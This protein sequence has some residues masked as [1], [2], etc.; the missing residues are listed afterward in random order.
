[1]N[2]MVDLKTHYQ[3]VQKILWIVLILNWAVAAAKIIYG[4]ITKSESM[5][6]DGFHSLSD[7][8]SN[9]I[10]LLGIRFCSKPK[11]EEHPY[12]HKKYE[13]LFA[14]GIAGMLIMVAFNLARE[15]IE[16]ILNPVVPQVNFV[17]FAVMFITLMVNYFVMRYEYKRG[18]QLQ[19]DILIVDSMHTRADIFTSISVIVALIGIKLGFPIID[20]IVT[21]VISGFIAFSALLIIKQ[22]SG[23]LVDASALND[24]KKIEE[25]VKSIKGV[26]SCHKI[27]T[28]GRLDDVFIDLHVQVEGDMR[29]RDAHKLS[30]SI[31]TKIMQA[32]PQIVDVIVHMEPS[33]ENNK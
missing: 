27:R 22:E 19:S 16:R 32:F 14:L 8:S 18:K 29:M 2:N 1:M 23:I 30:H 12:G 13:T 15:G 31:Q 21:L 26:R 3:K 20:P 6:A 7:G 4:L 5:T 25:V 11:D 10:G 17:S 9:L 24:T 33:T 28:R